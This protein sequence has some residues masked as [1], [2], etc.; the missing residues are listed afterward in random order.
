LDVAPVR[1]S[2]HVFFPHQQQFVKASRGQL[3]HTSD[4]LN[5]LQSFF[6]DVD[7]VH[8]PEELMPYRSVTRR[9][10]LESA[11][12][13]VAGAAIIPLNSNF[14]FAGTA[15][16]AAA[17]LEEFEYGQV[18]VTGELHQ[19]Q[20]Q[21]CVSVLMG[22]NEDSLLKPMRQMGG[23]PAPGADLGGWYNYDPN[24]DYR[25]FDAGFAPGAT[26]GQWVSAL[27]ARLCDHRGSGVACQSY[28]PEPTVRSKHLGRLLRLT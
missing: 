2:C 27:G 7:R 10:F 17:P 6:S 14:S 8:C 24:Y 28:P 15:A 1:K 21:H 25:T 18:A 19:A 13:S 4:K 12:L 20:L 11:T 23:Q 3:E 26:F 16:S 9:N 22:L 5:V